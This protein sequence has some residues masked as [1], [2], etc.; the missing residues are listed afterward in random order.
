MLAL[1]RWRSGGL[2]LDLGTPVLG[3]ASAGL[4]CGVKEVGRC[5]R[6]A[7][8]LVCL[9][10]FERSRSLGLGWPGPRLGWGDCGSLACFSALLLVGRLCLFL[11]HPIYPHFLKV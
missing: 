7:L 4:G 8:G 5:I 2:L 1:D 10:R 6:A 11:G 9:A 3:G